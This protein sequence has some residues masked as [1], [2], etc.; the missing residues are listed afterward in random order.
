VYVRVL[1]T[2]AVP[3]MEPELTDKA[4]LAAAVQALIVAFQVYVVPFG[5]A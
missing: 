5:A 2:E 1:P 4:A 3:A